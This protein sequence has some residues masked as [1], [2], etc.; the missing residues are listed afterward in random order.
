MLQ[1]RG[2]TA[3]TL[4]IDISDVLRVNSIHG[5]LFLETGDAYF[6]IPYSFDG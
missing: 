3:E 4:G 2:Y 6:L 1:S 5:V